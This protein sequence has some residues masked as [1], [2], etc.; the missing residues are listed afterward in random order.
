MEPLRIAFKEWAAICEA[1]AG[2]RQ[3]VIL[4]KG[5]VAE[6]GGEFR[7][8][9]AKFWLYPTFV[10]QQEGGLAPEGEPYLAAALASQP[11]PGVVRIRHIVE[12]LAVHC[13]MTLEELLPLQTR[14]IWSAATVAQRFHY[15]TPG[16][17]VLAVKVIEAPAFEF[18]E[19]PAQAGCKTWVELS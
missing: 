13:A 2:G 10:H 4:R 18:V 7:P 3:D 5:G 12:V 11:P 14:H 17:Y 1:L 19:T 8:E 15:R 6:V 9:H 16:L